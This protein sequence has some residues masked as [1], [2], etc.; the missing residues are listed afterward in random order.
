MLFCR[1]LSIIFLSVSCLLNTELTKAQ[2]IP[3]PFLHQAD[4]I[5]Q[6]SKSF[7]WQK[8]LGMQEGSSQSLIITSEYFLSP[9]GNSDPQAELNATLRAFALP[10]KGAPDNHAQCRFPGR[11]LWLSEQLDLSAFGIST[12]DCPGF[13]EF[14]LD[15]QLDSVSLVYVT[16]YL[17]NPASYYGHMLVKLNSFD[18]NFAVDLNAPAVNFG[19]IIPENEDM[20]S[21]VIKGI[22]GSYESGYTSRKYFY[23]AHNYGENELRDIWDYKLALNDFHKALLVAH[24]WEIIGVK[25]RYYF[26]NRNCAFQVSQLISL[27]VGEDIIDR[28]NLWVLPQD[29]VQKVERAPYGQSGL[30]KEVGYLSSRQSR[31][32]K[33]Y[34]LLSEKE[35]RVLKMAVDESSIMDA[36]LFKALEIESAQRVLDALIDYYQFRLVDAADDQSESF[37]RRYQ[38]ALIRRF[39]LPT[40]G[41]VPIKVPVVQPHIERKPSYTS[42]SYARAEGLESGRFNVRPAYYDT[43]DATSK[44]LLNSGLA[45]GA[46]LLGFYRDD[47]WIERLSLVDVENT[48]RNLTQLPGDNGRS[49]KLFLGAEQERQLCRECLAARLS[50]AGGYSWSSHGERLRISTFL[51]SGFHGEKW[52]ADRL[53]LGSSVSTNINLNKIRV[54]FDWQFQEFMEGTSLTSIKAEAR[55]PLSM[56]MDFRVWMEDSLETEAGFSFGIYF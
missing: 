25:Y 53:Y 18:R 2:L 34:E 8:M 37:E 11:Y 52:I 50:V 36:N 3:D 12:I 14:S 46:L 44:D 17:G 42:L 29:V 13:R 24:L 16:G 33:R 35:R 21:Y 15:G 56:N 1:R 6:L 45:M 4:Y 40:G 49:W 27:I 30:I 43:L 31:L 41:Q 32:Y 51:E 20:I 7:I 48:S 47:I 9:Y 10:I 38:Q 5:R 26:F 19:A 22:I 55:I 23:H 54:Q 28:R 39:S